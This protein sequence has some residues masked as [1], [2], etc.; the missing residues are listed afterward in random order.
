MLIW[1]EH[2]QRI[3]LHNLRFAQG[4]ETYTQA[5]NEHSDKVF[6]YFNSSL[7]TYMLQSLLYTLL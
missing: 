2:D 7:I 6:I 3:R 4:L 1:K 5:H